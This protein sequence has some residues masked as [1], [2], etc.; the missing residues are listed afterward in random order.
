M[1]W[2]SSDLFSIVCQRNVGRWFAAW[3]SRDKH[4][5]KYGKLE[6]NIK[7]NLRR[8]IFFLIEIKITRSDSFE[9]NSLSV[10]MFFLYLLF[11]LFLDVS[12]LLFWFIV[13]AAILFWSFSI[14]WSW[15]VEQSSSQWQRCVYASNKAK[16]LDITG[17]WD[18]QLPSISSDEVHYGST[19]FHGCLEHDY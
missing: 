7:R 5:G 1:T 16:Q 19:L 4:G 13:V 15:D 6:A 17:C 18:S 3:Q 10:W 14:F 8:P 9:N 12:V 11:V 2:P